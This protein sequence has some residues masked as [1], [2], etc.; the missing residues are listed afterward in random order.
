MVCVPVSSESNH[1]TWLLFCRLSKEDDED[2]ERQCNYERYR[3]LVENEASGCKCSTWSALHAARGDTCVSLD[4][5]QQNLECSLRLAAL[6]I[7]W[8]CCGWVGT[9]PDWGFVSSKP[10]LGFNSALAFLYA[11]SQVGK[12]CVLVFSFRWSKKK[13][14][15]EREKEKNRCLV[16]CI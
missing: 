9:G 8:R 6:V 13:R 14:E 3:T 15:R 1:F 10:S 7:W 2:E 4:S 12:C 11:Y 5:L 16:W